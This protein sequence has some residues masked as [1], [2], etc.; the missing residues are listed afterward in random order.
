MFPS[1]VLPLVTISKDDLYHCFKSHKVCPR[2]VKLFFE[3]FSKNPQ[4]GCP[5]NPKIRVKV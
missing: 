1:Q 3:I 4:S 2:S 5:P